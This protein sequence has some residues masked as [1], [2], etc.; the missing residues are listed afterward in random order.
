MTTTTTGLLGH[1]FDGP[2]DY[3]ERI[4]YQIWNEPRD[5]ESISNYYGTGTRI[6]TSAGDVVGDAAVVANTRDRLVAYP[7]FHGRIDDTIWTGS[8]DEGYRTSM[9]WT[10][11]GTNTG[12]S[13]FGPATGRPVVFQAIANCVVRGQVIVEEWLGANPLSQVRQL[14][15]PVDEVIPR[16]PSLPADPP[17]R[18][19]VTDVSGA[20]G[21]SVLDALDALLSRGSV[22]GF[23]ARCRSWLS[24]DDL[25]DGADGLAT[26]AER[27]SS[28]VADLTVELDDQY[29][30]PGD[31]ALLRV[32]SQLYLTGTGPTG[33]LSELLIAHHHVREG[34]VVG[35]WLA[36]DEL[37]LE[38][39]G[40]PLERAG[41]PAPPSSD[42]P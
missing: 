21:Q 10:W 20:A 31:D 32:A 18:H 42:R 33:A 13:P 38:R 24:A 40:V 7:D 3:I 8:E 25:V 37:A 1:G 12:P 16:L 39:R 29:E 41:V 5:V 4:T 22:R 14:G 15:L 6:H 9:R 30:Q 35:Q 11:T 36:Y 2:E 26:W 17:V 19:G 23:D 28:R 34:R 27:L